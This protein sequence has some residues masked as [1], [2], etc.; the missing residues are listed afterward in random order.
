MIMYSEP[1]L[2]RTLQENRSSSLVVGRMRQ[3]G[4]GAA[5][6]LHRQIACFWQG[7]TSGSR[8]T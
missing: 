4:C 8:R 2:W 5:W 1:V 6:E 7:V 3:L